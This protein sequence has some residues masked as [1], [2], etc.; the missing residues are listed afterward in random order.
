MSIKLKLDGFDELL[1]KIEKAGGDVDK[2]TENVMR[3]SANTMQHALKNQMIEANVDKSLISRMPPFEIEKDHGAITARVGYKKGA[4]NPKNPSDGYLVV[5]MNYG[6]PYRT[7]HG[8]IKDTTEGGTIRL[9]FVGRAKKKA[10]PKIR[11]QQEEALNKILARLK[12]R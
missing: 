9:G 4:F 5:F 11:K 3:Q 7:K 6:T 10:K 12:S 1:K 8:K 2:A